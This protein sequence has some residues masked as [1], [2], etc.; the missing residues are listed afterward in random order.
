RT[1]QDDVPPVA[2]GVVP[3]RVDAIEVVD[4][5]RPAAIRRP[6]R[7][8]H[9]LAGVEGRSAI[10]GDRCFGSARTAGGEI[11]C[12]AAV[13]GNRASRCRDKSKRACGQYRSRARQP[14]ARERSSQ[15]ILLKG[16][17]PNT[18]LVVLGLS[19]WGRRAANVSDTNDLALPANDGANSPHRPNRT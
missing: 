15:G 18:S 19:S 14:L 2:V 3:D 16:E 12:V 7:L 8:L 4:I 5:D 11:R 13:A 17:A 10:E 6:R 1:V 9:G